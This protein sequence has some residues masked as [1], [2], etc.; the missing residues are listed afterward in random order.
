[1]FQKFFISS[2]VL[3]GMTFYTINLVGQ[4]PTEQVFADEHAVSDIRND[5]FDE[6][7]QKSAQHIA[8]QESVEDFDFSFVLEEITRAD[9]A[10]VWIDPSSI[11]SKS[12]GQRLRAAYTALGALSTYCWETVKEERY[13]DSEKKLTL[14]EWIAS[15]PKYSYVF[16]SNVATLTVQDV[17]LALQPIKKELFGAEKVKLSAQQMSYLLYEL[18]KRG[19]IKLVRSSASLATAVSNKAISSIQSCK[20][21]VVSSVKKAL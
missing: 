10:E 11:P 2:A 5:L 15:L 20:D 13:Q 8:E 16:S 7:G 19:T 4:Q 14:R 3:C 21:C 1:M 6:L 9:V 12:L 18:S 17:E